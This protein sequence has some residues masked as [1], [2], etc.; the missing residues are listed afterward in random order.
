MY[1]HGIASIAL[2]E[3]YAMSGDDK[4]LREP[5]ER[6]LGF[7]M[8]SQ[9]QSGGG[10]RYGPGQ[11]GDTSVL[12]WQL[13]ALA[14]GAIAGLNIPGE[15]VLGATRYLNS[16][17]KDPQGA[18]YGYMPKTVGATPTMTAEALLCRMY[19]G[20]PRQNPA[21]RAGVNWLLQKLS[22]IHI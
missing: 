11:P 2:C 15:V 21:M 18:T 5:V 4:L 7:I 10:W 19:L 17:A 1:S 22:L 9:D 8:R 12:G 16:A 6:A 14:S 13:M 3:A 20:V